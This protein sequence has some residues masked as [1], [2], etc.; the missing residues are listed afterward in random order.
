MFTLL[1]GVELCV[2]CDSAPSLVDVKMSVDSYWDGVLDALKG[3]WVVRD[4][5]VMI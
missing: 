3:V 5:V 2:L 1:E 4:V